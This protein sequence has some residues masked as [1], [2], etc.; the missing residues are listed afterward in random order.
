MKIACITS[1][2]IPANTAN[3]IQVM[4]ACQALIQNNHS[5][6]LW[7]PGSQEF[8][9]EKLKTQYGLTETLPTTWLPIHPALKRYDFAF[10]ALSKA[11]S[12]D[13]EL[14]YTWM[15]QVALLAQIKNIPVVLELHDLPTG[16]IGPWL[17]KTIIKRKKNSRLLLI[18]E[19]LRKKMEKQLA[20]PLETGF[21]QIAPNGTEMQRYA[22][23][24]DPQTARKK[25]GLSER[26]TVAYT[27]HF[28][29]GRGME[30]ILDLI[31]HF[32]DVNFLIVGGQPEKVTEWQD[33]LQDSNI[34]NTHTTGFIDNLHLPIY[35]A[36]ADILLMPYGQTITGSGGGNTA[37][38]CSPMKMF[39]YM[40]VGRAIISSDLPVLHEVLD[41]NNAV[42]CPPDDPSAWRNALSTLVNNPEMR[43]NLG[44]Q[45][46]KDAEQ[47]SWTTR[48][49]KALQ[50]FDL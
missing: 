7:V 38:I 3:S 23:L 16:R 11:Q 19:A 20:L 6:H 39:D 44:I 34:N 5:I 27:G 26:L 12:W 33:L 45:A 32:P 35:Q 15:P 1:F 24:P 2:R 13:A 17:V 40:A 28:Y 21:V 30:I 48:A 47:Y 18:T 10:K 9:Q 22:D 36:A 8:S 42:F 31:R 43:S 46:H 41:E 4:K 29:H 14:I 50:G 37:D 49:L 25:L